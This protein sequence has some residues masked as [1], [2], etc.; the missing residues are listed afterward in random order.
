[1]SSDQLAVLDQ[2]YANA[3][4]LVG[5]VGADQWGASTPCTEWD[6]RALVNH[7]AFTSRTLA[8]S[9]QRSDIDVAPDDDL[10]GTTPVE[11]FAEAAATASASWRAPGALDGMTAIPADMP[12]AVALGINILDIGTHCWDL[13]TAIGQ[14]HGLDDSLVEAIDQWNRQVIT[15]DIR[16]IGFGPALSGSDA[17]GLDGMLAYVGRRG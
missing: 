11:S 13:A 17:G 16:G 6:V 12:A 2:L 15:D 3:N 4:R 8:S 14:D 1:M 9:A 7:M 5:S 10:L